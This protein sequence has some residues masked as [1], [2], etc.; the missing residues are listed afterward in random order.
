[1]HFA[2]QI[3]DIRYLIFEYLEPQD[4]ARLAKTNKAFFDV[5]TNELWKDITSVTPFLACLPQDYRLRP[6]QAQDLQRL[7]LYFSKVRSVV[8][9]GQQHGP[10]VTIPSQFTKRTK[11][12]K[13]AKTTKE[14][15]G[16]S[17][18]SLWRE[19]AEI[20]P[21]VDFL[22]NLQRIRIIDA[23]DEVCLPL[24]GISGSHLPRYT[25]RGSNS[26]IPIPMKPQSSR[27]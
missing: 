3:D 25:S 18:Q 12:S 24:V 20:R 10:K 14:T 6:L 23:M 27:C 15:G 8:F 22:P 4:F 9:E 1:M 7:D 13:T 26:G 11:T 19:I 17:W 2:W 21:P 16:K 5:A